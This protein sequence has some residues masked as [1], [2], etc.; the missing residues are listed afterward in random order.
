MNPGCKATAD[1]SLISAAFAVLP[2]VM[3][4][5]ASPNAIVA[6]TLRML[7]RFIVFS[8]DHRLRDARCQRAHTWNA[9]AEAPARTTK[10]IFGS[11]SCLPALSVQSGD[12]RRNARVKMRR[13]QTFA[14]SP[15]NAEVRPIAAIAES[16]SHGL[17]RKSRL[18]CKSRSAGH[19]LTGRS[20]VRSG[21]ACERQGLLRTAQ[22]L[23][24][25]SSM[26]QRVKRQW[27]V[28]KILRTSGR[29][30]FGP[31]SWSSGR[32]PPETP[33]S[34]EIVACGFSPERPYVFLRRSRQ[35]ASMA[36]WS[37]E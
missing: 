28:R 15:R 4:K 36:C 31:N 2:A 35:T 29:A 22:V 7:R 37:T 12:L 24:V 32:F 16:Q 11:K 20:R 17:S 33:R 14:R 1:R 34:H 23:D 3:A 21:R 19:G 18:T 10:V 26:V 5:K 25:G 6:E 8:S 9:G 13:F 27:Q 30:A